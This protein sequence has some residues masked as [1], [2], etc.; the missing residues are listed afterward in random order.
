MAKKTKWIDAIVR[1]LREER[2]ALHYTEIAELIAEREY[3]QVLGAT[4][5]RTVNAVISTDI[6]A[7]KEG[8]V[9]VRVGRGEFTLR[10]LL[11]EGG[12]ELIDQ[13]EEN[14]AEPESPK[15]IQSFG[16]YWSRP[17]VDW[18]SR[19]NLYG[20]EQIGATQ[21]N[22]REQIG[23]YLLH[24]ARETIYVGQAIDKPISER[25]F[26]HTRDRLGGR[27]DRFS[28]FGFRGVSSEGEL[29]PGLDFTAG[30][31]PKSLTDT[32]EAV[33]IESIEPRQNRKRGNA[34]D[35]IEFIQGTDPEIEK[36]RTKQMI[37][38]I[39]KLL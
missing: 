22:F 4:P 2:R 33:L 9:F 21:V 13:D 5:A 25:L 27:W 32:L 39:E 1:V 24:D 34:F 30:L 26:Q 20:M 23:I 19:P 17:E 18:K 35:G 28:W 11:G 38:K 15:L 36:K 29:N 7:K 14:V 8:S 16:I 6:K 37:A 31:T 10:E 3:Y 12:A